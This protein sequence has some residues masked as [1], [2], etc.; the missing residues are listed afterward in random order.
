MATTTSAVN[1]GES[2]QGQPPAASKP[3]P[4]VW[5]GVLLVAM[6]WAFVL[7]FPAAID[8]PISTTFMS[9]AGAGLLLTALFSLW[10]LA[11]LRRPWSERLIAFGVAAAG[12]V[13]ALLVTSQTLGAV[14]ALVTGL[15]I[16][17]TV[18]A[19][20]L[21]ASKWLAPHTA[22]RGLLLAIAGVWL[23][24]SLI[25]VDGVDGQMAASVH[26]RWTPTAEEVYVAER[27]NSA[28]RAASDD[29]TTDAV[30]EKLTLSAGDW[31]GYRGANC[32][33][34]QDHDE[35]GTDWQQAP[36]KLL[37][38]R[39]VGPAWSS[40]VVIGDK[41]FT[42]EQRGEEEA[43]VCLDA[44]TGEERW[45]HTDRARFWDGQAGAGPR[46]TPTFA[47][48]WLYG[49]GATGVLNCLDAATGKVRWSRDLVADTQAPMPMW[50][51]SS[52]P[53]VV[54]GRVIVFA[55]GTN[56][57]GIVAYSAETGEPAWHAPCGPISYS[58]AQLVSLAGAPQALVL[59]DAGVVAVDPASG[60]VLWDYKSDGHGI[61]RVAQPRPV[62]DAQVLVGSEDMGLVLLE[63]AREGDGFSANER[64][65]TKGMRPAYNDFVVVD[66]HAYGFDKGQFC[67]ID[68]ASGKRAWKAGRYGY[69][70]V[71]LLSRQKLLLVLTE[72]GE[73]V[74]LAANPAK[75]EELGRIEAISGK[76][77]NHPVVAHGRLYVR[78]DSQMAAFDLS[79]PGQ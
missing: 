25:R 64:W 71:L 65:K 32:L 79:K 46:G 8:A 24:I 31:P 18:W 77:W 74:L 66:D 53:L 13:V 14:G 11:S 34:E 10:W 56:D 78:N 17:F 62:S 2:S 3:A 42:Q 49:L 48:G 22:R 21:V 9:I 23:L 67:A 58:S 51:F 4:R 26:W 61:W 19:I 69:G 36:P 27:A 54:D 6:Y 75:H 44:T 7:I 57:R 47:D 35:I 37:W 55:G 73:V 72:Q 20:W 16:L 76:T 28:E 38:K 59:S 39:S 68:L 60:K 52:S 70:Q 40:F 1:P 45:V 29:A 50:G 33:G 15:P 41:L 30:V 12:A 43:T 63:V 5:P